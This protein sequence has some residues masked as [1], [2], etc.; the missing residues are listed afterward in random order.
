VEQDHQRPVGVA[1]LADVEVDVA[2]VDRARLAGEVLCRA[3]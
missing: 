1:E 3:W 2:D